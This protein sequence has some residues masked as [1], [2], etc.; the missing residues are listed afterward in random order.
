MDTNC[1]VL[2]NSR[3]EML[4]KV[5][6][7]PLGTAKRVKKSCW[8]MPKDYWIASGQFLEVWESRWEM[9]KFP[10]SA[11]RRQGRIA[12]RL[13]AK[14]WQFPSISLKRRSLCHRCCAG[15]LSSIPYAEMHHHRNW[16]SFR[17]LCSPQAGT[18]SKDSQSV[19]SRNTKSSNRQ[20][21]QNQY[22]CPSWQLSSRF[23]VFSIAGKNSAVRRERELQ[24]LCA[25]SRAEVEVTQTY[26]LYFVLLRNYVKLRPHVLALPNSSRHF[27]QIMVLTVKISI[28]MA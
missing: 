12:Q 10:P 27:Q 3:W 25:K 28:D 5:I 1:S 8:E 4:L 21:P 18:S 20:Q 15:L 19:P 7:Q 17:L 13:L 23:Y 16:S 14:T 11:N 24:K 2:A 6:G 9:P 22:G 26:V